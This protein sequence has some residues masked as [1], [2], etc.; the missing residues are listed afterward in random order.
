MELPL[1]FLL[2]DVPPARLVGAAAPRSPRLYQCS[3]AWTKSISLSYHT[4][5]IEKPA[6]I[7]TVCQPFEPIGPLLI[8]TRINGGF[9]I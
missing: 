5:Q 6:G 3:E 8:G 1:C 9:L 2:P 4:N 7:L